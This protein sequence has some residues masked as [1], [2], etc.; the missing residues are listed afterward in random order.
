MFI[1]QTLN[2]QPCAARALLKTKEAVR[3]QL[4]LEEVVALRLATGLSLSL[5]FS[6]SRSLARSL[7]RSP[8]L[9]LA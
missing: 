7:D 5:S 4:T 1:C 8:S 2:P 3:A 6:L 9:P